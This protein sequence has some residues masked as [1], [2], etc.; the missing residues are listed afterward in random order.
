MCR[1]NRSTTPR[2]STWNGRAV[3]SDMQPTPRTEHDLGGDVRGGESSFT[4]AGRGVPTTPTS[5][6]TARHTEP[7]L[8]SPQG[9]AARRA[10]GPSHRGRPGRWVAL[11]GIATVCALSSACS[12]PRG[13]D[14]TALA[15]PSTQVGAVLTLTTVGDVLVAGTTTG[16][17][18]PGL[19]VFAAGTWTSRPVRPT[20]PYGRVAQWL[21]IVDSSDGGLLA[22]GGARGGAHSNVRW[23]VW[24]ASSCRA[25]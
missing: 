20:T 8:A 10:S 6:H 23:S 18:E 25:R 14:W 13:D 11:A 22:I 9:Y 24:R 16:S 19:Q 5:P 21:S 2:R 7:V 4:V 15:P 17:G 1:L 3:T 12:P